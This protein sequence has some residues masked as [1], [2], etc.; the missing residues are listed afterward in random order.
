MRKTTTALW[1]RIAVAITTVVVFSGAGTVCFAADTM[2]TATFEKDGLRAEIAAQ[3]VPDDIYAAQATIPVSL[4]QGAF[5]VT[6]ADTS[7]V[8]EIRRSGSDLVIYL[9]NPHA[10]SENGNITFGTISADSTF[11]VGTAAE[12]LLAD[13]LLQSTVSAVKVDVTKKSPSASSGGGSSSSDRG[14]S[15]DAAVKPTVDVTEHGSV[16]VSA[17]GN[18]IT[19][20]SD[21]GYEIAD[22]LINGK[23][24]GAV[25]SYTFDSDDKTRKVKV[26]FRQKAGTS[27]ATASTVFSD[28][29]AT[30]WA[31]G[32][33]DYV[34]AKKL[35]FG[36]DTNSFSPND[37]MTR[38]MFVT[39]MSRFETSLGDK[40]KLSSNP[41]GTFGDVPA[42]AWYAPAVAWSK[43]ANLVSGVEQG[44]F[45]PEASITREQIAV[46]L[47]RYADL[48]G[49][50]LPN[51]EQAMSFADGNMISPWAQDAVQ[52]A[53]M[54]GILHGREDGNF[55]A[56]DYATRA[57]VA[58][59]LER[60]IK[61]VS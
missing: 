12:L 57:E 60:F 51:K 33:I 42:D 15:S 41:A 3:N 20:V 35:F 56:Q 30:H 39:V 50:T 43:G 26:I 54:A 38:A 52:K 1:R 53:Q 55:A 61:V 11:S 24:V 45:A 59:M 5:S 37:N 10:I 22:V 8:C 48:C 44:I 13:K 25:S 29:P 31:K 9:D 14:K 40:W 7:S 23:S 4:S 58:S 34:V 27:I 46:L 18:S 6:P 19:I 36:T 16:K 32:S 17:D 2:L 28:V 21:E 47:V 49:I